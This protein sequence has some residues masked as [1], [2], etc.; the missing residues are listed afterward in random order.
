MTG[1]DQD[2]I[3]RIAAA[4][5]WGR[6]NDAGQRNRSDIIAGCM[7]EPAANQ[8]AC[9]WLV[10]VV[11]GIEIQLSGGDEVVAI[12]DQRITPPA[13]AVAEERPRVGGSD[14]ALGVPGERHLESESGCWKDVSGSADPSVFVVVSVI[15]LQEECRPPRF[16][17]REWL[18]F[19]RCHLAVEPAAKAEFGRTDEPKVTAQDVA[20]IASEFGVLAGGPKDPTKI[21][22]SQDPGAGVILKQRAEQDRQPFDPVVAAATERERG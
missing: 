15:A 2:S 5:R 3:G 19:D 12:I 9:G 1:I 18:V 13:V 21:E 11:S 6:P 8:P 17:R 22:P 4:G 14:G 10:P 16:R 20:E 7:F